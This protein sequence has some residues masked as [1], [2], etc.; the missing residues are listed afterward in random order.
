VFTLHVFIINNPSTIINC[1]KRF[2]I[3][4]TNQSTEIT[5]QNNRIKP[6][7]PNN[8]PLKAL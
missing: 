6:S 8:N 4:V 5:S 3:S 1:L 7:L 2:A